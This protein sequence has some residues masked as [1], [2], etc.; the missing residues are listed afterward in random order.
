[1]DLCKEIAQILNASIFLDNLLMGASF[2]TVEKVWT[3]N[4]CGKII[5]WT[6]TINVSAK[7]CQKSVKN[8]S[9]LATWVWNT[10]PTYGPETLLWGCPNK[11]F[12]GYSWLL[13]EKL[14]SS[15]N[16]SCWLLKKRELLWNCESKT[17]C[18]DISYIPRY[19]LTMLQK[20]TAF[21]VYL[22]SSSYTE[23]SWYAPQIL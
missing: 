15:K 16:K 6:F 9:F 14:H 20:F 11:N 22:P 4:Q 13:K 21:Q 19:S 3:K 1:M 7:K 18:K 12:S 8:L 23:D 2:E 5:T 10:L 17:I